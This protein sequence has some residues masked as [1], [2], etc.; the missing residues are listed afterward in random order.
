[1]QNLADAL[2]LCASHPDA[3][4]GTYLVSD[5]E[6]LSTPALIRNLAHAMGART[7]LVPVPVSL[8]RVVGMLM[9]KQGEIDRLC[10]SLQ[11][12]GGKICH[13][14]GWIP[15]KSAVE[16]L[17]VTAEWFAKARSR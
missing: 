4:G 9:G 16:G 17:A 6:D 14:L 3:A 13:D 5:G 15:P 1:M 12:E 7:R 8:L 2:K 11:V 10:Q